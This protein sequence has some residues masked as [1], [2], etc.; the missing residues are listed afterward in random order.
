M[1]RREKGGGRKKK[2]EGQ[3][4]KGKKLIELVMVL[5]MLF[6]LCLLW[7]GARKSLPAVHT[8]RTHTSWC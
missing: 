7:L 2:V 8:L 5:A 6:A 4:K 3:K 1:M